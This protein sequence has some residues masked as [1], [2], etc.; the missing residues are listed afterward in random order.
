MGVELK[1][2]AASTRDREAS[3]LLGCP[4]PRVHIN[5]FSKVDREVGNPVHFP[6]LWVRDLV[7]VAR[8]GK[9]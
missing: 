9:S 1:T 7:G 8:L 6:M 5:A 3:S 2:E 4:A